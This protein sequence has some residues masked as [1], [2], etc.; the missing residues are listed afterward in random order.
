MNQILAYIE[1]K[2]TPSYLG[3]GLL[4]GC[5]TDSEFWNFYIEIRNRY[6]QYVSILHS[7]GKSY[8][9]R[10]IN[11]FFLDNNG[12]KPELKNIIFFGSLIHSRECL[13][14]SMTLHIL[15]TLIRLLENKDPSILNIF[16]H[17][18]IL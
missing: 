6:P 5:F 2:G 16:A 10:Q 13:T 15:T 18:R 9:K 14:L 7:I 1:G 3:K 17:N 8:E 11:S 4:K 12:G